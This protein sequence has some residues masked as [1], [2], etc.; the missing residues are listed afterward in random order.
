MSE[1][2]SGLVTGILVIA[3]LYFAREVFV[4]LAL[5]GLLAFLMA[6]AAVRLER[7]GVKRAPAALLV[8]FLSLT[9]AGVL[10]WVMLGQIYNLAVELP[11]YQQNLT[12]KIETLHLNSA[13]R[14]TST[15]AMLASVGKQ[16]QGGTEAPPIVSVTPRRR[17]SSHSVPS[18]VT[19]K[20]A[21]PVVV[22][23]EEPEQS[24]LA[25]AGRTMIPLVHP[26]TTTFIVV[27]FLVFMLLGREGLRDRGL[28]LAGSGR[29]HLTTTAIEDASRRVSRYLQMQL[30]VNLCYGVVVGLLLWWIGIPNPLLWG[31]LTCLLRFVPYIGILMAAAGPL[32]LSIAVS[33]HWNQLI[34]ITVMYL[35]LELITGNFVEPML[36]GAST[37]IS[38]IAILIA[39]IFWTLLWGLPG[40]LL[41]T[42]LTV[43][44]V[45]IGRQVPHLYYLDVL[46]G[47]E[48]ALPPPERFYQRML[49]SH[50][51][52][53]RMLLEEMLKTKSREEVYDCVLVPALSM[54]EE[55]RHAENMTG[56]RAEQV[57]QAVEELAEDVTSRAATVAEVKPAKRVA[58][59]P[60]RDFAD[61]VACQLALQVLAETASTRVISADTSTQDLL[62]SLE[63][64]KADVICVVGVPPSAIRH[65][66]L[67][68]HQIRARFPDAVV[69]ACV[70]RK[71]GDLSNLRSRIPMDDAQHVVC[72]LL[73]MKEYLTSLLHPEA[74]LAEEPAAPERD[75]KSSD[76]ISETVQEIQQTDVLDG[77]EEDVFNRL[78]TNLARSF[79]APIALI[80]VANGQ[81]RFWEAQCGFPED[82]LTMTE[83]EQDLS[84]CSR[85][86]FSD[87]SLVIADTAEEEQFANDPFLKAKGIRF[88]AGAPLKAHDGEIIGSLCVLDTRPRQISEQQKEMLTSIANSVMMAIDLHSTAP[89]DEPPPQPE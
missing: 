87:A 75:T 67:R 27:I 72:S 32:M 18:P 86:V 20:T 71:E 82:T 31:V 69:V 62:Q 30:V 54:I 9:G 22:R 29:M 81:R 49:S 85:I 21:Q 24:M 46:F 23:V 78:A 52:E 64:G 6:P 65:I 28:R 60:A 39:A 84:I 41:S 2:N 43:C 17:A 33:P 40:L 89:P 56:A 37:G 4:P 5:A 68:C 36:Y 3:V 45:V 57:L 61:E 19:N 8:I 48:A 16:I 25:V 26:L 50:V 11:Q 15:V 13:G 38:A 79:D 1:R 53:A 42:P 47:E 76:A 73:L 58:C 51:I 70:L 14:L 80:T 88:Y 12:G 66:R 35:V 34:W 83:R 7:W 44:L 10:G 77:P 55:A 74:L 63:N 59:V